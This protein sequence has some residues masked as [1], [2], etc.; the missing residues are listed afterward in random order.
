MSVEFE[1]EIVIE[2]IEEKQVKKKKFD[3][4][5]FYFL[6]RRNIQSFVKYP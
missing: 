5:K 4:E 1:S 6:I 2:K 3:I